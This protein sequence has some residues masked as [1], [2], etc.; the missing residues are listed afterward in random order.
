MSEPAVPSE[1]EVLFRRLF[2]RYD[3]L[4]HRGLIAQQVPGWDSLSH[5]DL[6]MEI[7]DEMNVVIEPSLAFDFVNLG[8]LI[9]YVEARRGVGA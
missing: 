5:A 4:V 6:I 8:A 1:Y 7:E 3:G 9:D 2:K